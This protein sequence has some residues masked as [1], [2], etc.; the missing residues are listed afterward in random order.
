MFLER[1]LTQSILATAVLTHV[2]FAVS[3]MSDDINNKA[4]LDMLL[5]LL[6]FLV[7]FRQH[8]NL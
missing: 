2:I 4:I 6:V 3:R 8:I 7:L 5:N 1:K